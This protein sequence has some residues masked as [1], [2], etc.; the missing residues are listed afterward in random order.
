[1]NQSIELIVAWRLSA[2]YLIFFGHCTD[3]FA[4]TLLI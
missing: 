4:N 3:V 2:S 1:L